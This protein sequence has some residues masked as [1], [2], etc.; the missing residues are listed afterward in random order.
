MNKQLIQK[1]TGALL[2][3]PILLSAQKV[4]TT[5]VSKIKKEG[6]EKSQVMNILSMLTD[7]HGPR[8]TN[9]PGFKKAAAYSKKSLEDWG[10]SNVHYDTWTDEFGR[11]WSLKRFSL[12][13]IEPVYFPVIA[14]PKAWTP[15][16]KKPIAAEVI[17]LDIKKEEDLA[18]YKGKLKGKIVLFSLPTPVKPGFKPDASRLN[19]STLLA[20]AN[21]H[22]S[23]SQGGRRF[24]GTNEPQRLAYLKWQLCQSEG[25]IAVIDASPASRLEDG[26]LTVAS[27][28]VPY[29]AETPFDK[30]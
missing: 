13:A 5:T 27:A 14:Y 1:I 11:G 3:L 20:M 15:G 10:L 12:H 4:D 26:T 8:L 30:R 23:E 16:L 6:L 21:A 28:S 25:A 29:P 18:K 17:Y 19:D 2:C 22:V 7:V 9:S 24:T